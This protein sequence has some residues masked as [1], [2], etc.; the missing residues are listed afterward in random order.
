ME[1]NIKKILAENESLITVLQII[2]DKYGFISEEIV[3][4]IEKNSEYSASFIYSVAS[5]YSGFRFQ[6]S[7]K[8]KINICTGTVCYVKGADKIIHEIENVLGIKNDEITEDGTFSLDTSRCVGC[9]SLAPVMTIDG[10]VYG[11]VKVTD[12]KKILKKYKG[13]V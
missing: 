9:C 7:G 2:Q 1:E 4:I 11:N 12:V 6:K 3:K 8:Y 13:D 10:D 5:F